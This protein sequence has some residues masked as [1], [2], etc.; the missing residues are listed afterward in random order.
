MLLLRAIYKKNWMI[1][2]TKY[3]KKFFYHYFCHWIMCYT[4]WTK[5]KQQWLDNSWWKPSSYDGMSTKGVW[6]M[7]WCRI[8]GVVALNPFMSSRW[9]W[10]NCSDIHWFLKAHVELWLKKNLNNFRKKMIFIHNNISLHSVKKRM[11]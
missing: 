2:T 1:W 3:I 6:L 4:W 5:Q 9:C 11:F 10:N 8:I 7:F